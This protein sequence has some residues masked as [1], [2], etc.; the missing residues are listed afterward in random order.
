MRTLRKHWPALVAALLIGLATVAPQIIFSVRAGSDFHGIYAASNGD[1]LYYVARIRD[2]TEGHVSASNPYLFEHKDDSYP[3]ATGGEMFV[4]GLSS[5]FRMDPVHLQVWLDFIA[6]FFIAILTYILLYGLSRSRW[7]SSAAPVL[8]SVMSGGLGKPVNPEITFPLL[9]LF[10]IGWFALL[11]AKEEGT[12]KNLAW[13]VWCGSMLGLLFLTYFFHWSFL[14]VVMGCYGILQLRQRRFTSALNQALIACIALIVAIPYLRSLI[15]YAHSSFSDE[16]AVR[17][18]V[19]H[20]HF[21]ETL[22]RSAVAVLACA[23]FIF[24]LRRWKLWRDQRAQGVLSLLVANIVY[25]NH[26][27]LS[28]LIIQ[29]ANHWSFM[30]VFL[31][32]LALA[33]AYPFLKSD[34]SSVRD[35]WIFGVGFLALFLVPLVRLMTFQPPFTSWFDVSQPLAWQRYAPLVRFLNEKTPLDSVVFANPTLS[36]LL[37]AYT[38]DNVY[39]AW[40]IFNMPASDREVME[41]YLLSHVFEPDFYKDP[42]LGISTETQVLWTQPFQTE[43]NTQ[44]VQ[45]LFHIP[46]E[47]R[48]SPTQEIAFASSTLARLRSRGLDLRALG[49]YRLDYI[50]WDTR[51]QPG[52]NLDRVAGLT[53]VFQD[54]G[55]EVFTVPRSAARG[56]SN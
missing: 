45:R 33:F 54:G 5:L 24:F 22:S 6:P 30:P 15:L 55:I 52:W 4:A 20:S 42:S 29:N 39:Y 40:Y 14:L 36:Y 8:L 51:D 34:S 9:L 26:Q 41:R 35:R 7:V 23:F 11:A 31:M 18:G 21:P 10:L 3:Q 37:P 25:P 38:H 48:H 53:K 56:P 27:I 17:V 46:T 49:A 47:E 32:M 19:T 12:K 43:R 44:S 1:W 2:V 50:V 28:G 16:T 13:I